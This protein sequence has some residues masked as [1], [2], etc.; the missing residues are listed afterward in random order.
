[1]NIKRS[2]VIILFSLFYGVASAASPTALEHEGE[3]R[4]IWADLFSSDVDASINFYTNTFGWKV[5]QNSSNTDRYLLHTAEGE[6]VANIIRY[7]AATEKTKNAVWVGYISTRDVKETI[8]K[9]EPLGSHVFQKQKQ[10]D[11]GVIRAVISDLQG[12]VIGLQQLD[13]GKVKSTLWSQGLWAWAQ[14]FSQNPQQAVSFYSRLLGYD[15]KKGNDEAQ[16][17]SFILMNEGK[18][19]MA[20]APLPK[21]VAQ[22]DRWVGFISVENINETV[23]LAK[24][25]GGSLL[26]APSSESFEPSLAIIIDPNGALMG[27][28]ETE[29]ADQGEKK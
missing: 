16:E 22:R 12:G 28:I 13:E 29:A 15:F 9:A 20:V 21:D 4:F 6:P 18:A 17:R 3:G 10:L 8:Q 1:M 23:T 24:K 25:M 11:E 19:R 14:L 2:A 7:T 5:T 26:Y 27:L